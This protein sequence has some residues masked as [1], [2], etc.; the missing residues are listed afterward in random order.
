VG[1]MEKSGDYYFTDF[2]EHL[3]LK[4]VIIGARNSVS[5]HR[6]EAILRSQESEVTIRKTRSS[7]NSFEIVESEGAF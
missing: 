2:H 7:Y 4:E 1:L 5:R 6:I 3:R